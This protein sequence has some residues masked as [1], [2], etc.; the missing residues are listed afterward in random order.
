MVSTKRIADTVVSLLALV[1]LAPLLL[2]ISLSIFAHD[3]HSPFYIAPRVG[4]DRRQFRMIKFRSMVV[5]ADKTGVTSTSAQDRRI[6]PIGRIVRKYKFDELVQLWNVMI[7]DMS[8]VGPRPN[9]PSAV[10]GYTPFEETLLTVRPG[11]TDFASMIFADEGEILRDYSDA[12]AAYDALIR[13]WK[14]RLGVFYVR[15]SSLFVDLRLILLTVV[16]MFSRRTA[17]NALSRELSRLGAPADLVQVALRRDALVP[18][19]LDATDP[20]AIG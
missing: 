15:N 16:G 5:G 2:L 13:P 19:A 11:I 8:L 7:G 10:A 1:I 3:R 4:K 12:D 20:R 18:T 17:L 9:V 14:S 6:T